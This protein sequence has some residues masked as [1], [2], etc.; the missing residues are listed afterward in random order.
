MKDFSPIQYLVCWADWEPKE[1]TPEQEARYVAYCENMD[2]IFDPKMPEDLLPVPSRE[3]D[4]RCVY[5]KSFS[6]MSEAIK[7]AEDLVSLS[8]EWRAFVDV[9]KQTIEIIKHYS[10]G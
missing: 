10:L 7:F 4:V 5:E 8:D 9:R 6:T 3:I 1:M 2:D